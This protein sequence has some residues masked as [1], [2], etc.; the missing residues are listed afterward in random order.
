MQPEEIA[1]II[2]PDNT[3]LDECKEAV[4]WRKR[5]QKQEEDKEEKWNPLPTKVGSFQKQ[6][7]KW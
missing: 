3:F 7:E 1:K 2:D 4:K 6:K 5:N